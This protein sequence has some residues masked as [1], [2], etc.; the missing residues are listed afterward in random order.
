MIRRR[1]FSPKRLRLLR[2]LAD[3]IFSETPADPAA[4][5]E[6]DELVASF[7]KLF[8]PALP[9]EQARSQLALLVTTLLEE[10]TEEEKRRNHA[11][12]DA[13]TSGAD[14][15][16]LRSFNPSEEA[17]IAEGMFRQVAGRDYRGAARFR[18][19]VSSNA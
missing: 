14:G 5:Q 3:A 16:E 10:A 17:A 2:A 13:S 4:R 8:F 1:H 6:N 19:S 9:E 15:E 12:R 7:A 18:D 11:R